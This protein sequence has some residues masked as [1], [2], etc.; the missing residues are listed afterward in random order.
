[1][2]HPYEKDWA[3][4]SSW[5]NCEEF[6]NDPCRL[7]K[8]L[9]YTKNGGADFTFITDYVFDFEWGPSSKTKSENIDMADE[10]I[11]VT[12]DP[13]N[14]GHQSLSSGSRW[15]VE[16]DLF[17][18]D[19]FF[20][21]DETMILEDG[22]TIVKTNEYMYIAASHSSG[23]LMNVYSSNWK[24]GFKNLK[25]VSMP[26]GQPLSRTFTLMDDAEGQVWLF[27]ESHGENSVFGDLYISDEDGRY[28]T[29][30]I[31]NVIKAG[32]VDFERVTSLDGTYIVNKFESRSAK[33]NF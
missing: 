18:S 16:I 12:R 23:E 17:V 9:F 27:M 11:F 24:S 22:N 19:T 10:R 15:S 8:E 6:G 29:L 5:T 32:A 25:R 14:S 7:Y 31:E 4:A 3:L 30:S 28:F 26:G 33:K 21:G 1:M 20:Q 13:N 2:F